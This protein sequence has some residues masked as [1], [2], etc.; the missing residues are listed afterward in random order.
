[1]ISALTRSEAP[2]L[3][4]VRGVSK[5]YGG[6]QALVEA[7][8]TLH[9]GRVHALVGENGAGKST[10]MKIIAGAEQADEGEI[11]FRQTP[12]TATNVAEANARGIQ[13]V[14]QELSLFPDLDVLTN[15]FL[16]NES[17]R[18]G[19]V[20]R[21][22]MRARA[23]VVLDQIGL[24]VD[25]NEPVGSLTLGER[26]LVEIAHALL[27][28]SELLILDEPN[29]A[30]NAA[31]TERLFTVIRQLRDRNVAIIYVSHRLE[32]VFAISDEISVLRNGQ[33]IST[34]PV[35]NYSIGELVTEMIGRT[36]SEFFAKREDVEG[37]VD[38]DIEPSQGLRLA[39]VRVRGLAEPVNLKAR[40]G[41]V[42]GLAGLEGAGV[43]AV[44]EAVFGMRPL[45][46]GSM[47]LPN[48]KGAPRSVRQAVRSGVALIPSDRRNAGLMLDQSVLD[49]VSLVSA[50]T[51]GGFGWLPQRAM[52]ER[53][54]RARC[55]ELNVK[56]PSVSTP[57]NQL[58][59]GTQQKVVLAK[60]LE[61]EP[62]V[63]LLDDPTRGVDVGTKPEIYRIAHRLA[64]QGRVVLFTSSELP[65]FASVCDRVLIFYRGRVCGELPR[66]QLADGRLLAAI[67]TGTV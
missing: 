59:G 54:V 38:G 13:I 32:E 43:Q 33:V 12:L 8:L 26:Q 36:P 67:N 48:G 17:R 11:L 40:R 6:V 44:L 51:L 21:R 60:W 49:N 63:V 3:C 55:E 46:Q 53:R 2:P 45:L 41:E 14:F 64:A 39:D 27:S 52:L 28:D 30:L 16:G 1:V 31:E 61:T 65:E 23:R 66:E 57:V 29:S 35:G 42:V 10:L 47:T 25:V 37:D 62:D 18:A 24:R 15:L 34:R 22:Q 5:S 56:T 20:N 50:G 7:D 4:Q 19:V 9:Q 58:S